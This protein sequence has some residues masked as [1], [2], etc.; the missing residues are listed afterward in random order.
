M[1][2]LEKAKVIGTVF[3]GG[4]KKQIEQ[5]W[6]WGAAVSVGLHQGLKYKGSI[7]SGVFGGLAVLM[8]VAGANGVYNVVSLWED[9]KTKI[10]NEGV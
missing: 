4:V 8:V 3:K 5:Q 7:K 6:T 2:N 10:F 1:T 9:I